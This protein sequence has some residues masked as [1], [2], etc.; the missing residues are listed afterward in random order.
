M[1]LSE[2]RI[3]V[4][5]GAGL[6]GSA[7]IWALNDLGIEDIVVCDRMSNDE[8]YRNLVPLHFNDYVDADDLMLY[9][10]GDSKIRTIF[11]LGACADTMEKDCRF[12]MKNNFEFTKTLAH[13]AEN[14]GIR[15]IYASSAATY[16]DGAQGMDDEELRLQDLRPRNPYGYSKHLFDIYAQSQWMKLYGIK[17]FNIFGPNEYHKGAMISKVAHAYIQIRDTGEVKLFKSHHPSYADGQQRRDFLYIKDAVAMTIFLGNAAEKVGN[18]A[19]TGIYNVG[20]GVSQTWID[21]V[22]PIFEVLQKPQRIV[23]IDMPEH[24]RTQYQYYTCGNI[25]KI[26]SLGYEAPLTPLREAVIDYVANYLIP[27]K[28]LGE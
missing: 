17:Y 19:T 16:G 15:F 6:I 5:G 28:H 25:K 11:H 13:C 12:L 2:G 21:L 14:R 27:G 26:R 8:R 7:L 10:Q 24:L 22:A 1:R 18:H 9:L 4:T 3:L 20:S 23:F